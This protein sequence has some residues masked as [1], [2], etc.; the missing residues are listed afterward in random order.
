MIPRG[1]VGAALK[2]ARNL[3]SPN[4]IDRLQSAHQMSQ[5]NSSSPDSHH[6]GAAQSA[7]SSDSH[8][9]DA[10]QPANNSNSH[11]QSMSLTT[12][13]SHSHHKS[14]AS[15][16]NQNSNPQHIDLNMVMNLVKSLE[17]KIR[18]ESEQLE[19]N[20]VKHMS[21]LRNISQQY[22][23]QINNLIHTHQQQFSDFEA[24]IQG[25]HY[26]MLTLK[27]QL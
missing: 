3:F 27:N 22:E 14:T 23:S 13:S 17:N 1:W 10:A 5:P 7:S 26:E 21:D 4:T 9:L 18:Q 2:G 20:R 16:S 8:H 19:I 15:D 6:L 12:N 24:Q 11:H 25:K